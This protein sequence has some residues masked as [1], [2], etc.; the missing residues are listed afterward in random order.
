MYSFSNTAAVAAK[1]EKPF[2][3]NQLLEEIQPLIDEYFV[4]N[5]YIENDEL[6]IVFLPAQIFFRG[7]DVEEKEGD[8]HPEIFRKKKKK[9]RGEKFFF[10]P[11]PCYFCTAAV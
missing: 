10:S 6:K 4:C 9:G 3:K 5:T 7:A 8:I 2:G 1:D 11:P